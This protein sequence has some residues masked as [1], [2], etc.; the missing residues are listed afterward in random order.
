V[1]GRRRGAFEV[2]VR[3]RCA[4]CGIRGCGG[5]ASVMANGGGGGGESGQYAG[6]YR[7]GRAKAVPCQAKV[8]GVLIIV[9]RRPVQ[10]CTESAA[11]EREDYGVSGGLSRGG[12]AL[13]E[14]LE[15]E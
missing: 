14:W 11:D 6:G 5:T 13:V 8:K 15:A 12:A 10:G 1:A 9:S 4:Q 3:M 2:G 7:R